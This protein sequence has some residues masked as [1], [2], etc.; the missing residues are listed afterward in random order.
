[1]SLWLYFIMKNV[2]V[3]VVNSIIGIGSECKGEFKAGGVL[4]IDGLFS[5]E[6]K[7]DGKVII[8]K[9]GVVKTDIHVGTIIIGGTMHGNV[10]AS[11]QVQLLSTAHLKGDIVTP[12]LVVEEGVVLE[13]NCIINRKEH[14]KI[15]H[16]HI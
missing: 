4:R 11:K 2:D 9:T 16:H 15:G 6:L 10:Y 3:K 5:G 7:T 14:A 1:V 8:G 13:G 12:S